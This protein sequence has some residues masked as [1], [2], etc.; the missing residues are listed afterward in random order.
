MA[1]TLQRQGQCRADRA[2]PDDQH[3]DGFSVHCKMTGY[4]AR[5]E[6]EVRDRPKS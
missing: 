4:S 5:Q 3:V 2:T 6:N 1:A